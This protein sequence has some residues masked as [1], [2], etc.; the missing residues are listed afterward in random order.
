METWIFQF[1]L[2]WKCM[3]GE[4]PGA[5]W[6]CRT[7]SASCHLCSVV[8]MCDVSLVPKAYHLRR[9]ETDW[10]DKPRES[11]LEN[12]HLDRKLPER[13]VHSRPLSQHQEQ[14]STVFS[15]LVWVINSQF[16]LGVVLVKVRDGSVK[17]FASSE[18]T[19]FEW[20]LWPFCQTMEVICSSN[21]CLLHLYSMASTGTQ[22]Q[23]TELC[24][25][26][27]N[28]EYKDVWDSQFSPYQFA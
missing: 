7:A 25:A 4:E 26:G 20:C 15:I 16:H 2:C 9:E 12:G 23:H 18:T 19:G 6:S 8:A 28:T 27:N 11:R 3:C 5:C 13:L 21:R 14:V 22:G 10:F 17:H 1:P 24:K